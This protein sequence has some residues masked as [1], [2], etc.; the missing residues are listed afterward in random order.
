MKHCH[1]LKTA[2]PLF[3]IPEHCLPSPARCQ[4]WQSG[5]L[6]DI[7]AFGKEGCAEC[8]LYQ[9]AVQ[10]RGLVDIEI[11]TTLPSSGLIVTLSNFLGT[12][13]HPYKDQFIAAIVADYLPHPGAHLQILQN[14]QHARRL[15][16]SI[17]MPLWPQPGLIPRDKSRGAKFERIAFF[18]DLKNLA[19]ELAASEWRAKLQ[20]ELGLELI[21]REKER[22]HDY[23]DIDAVIGIRDFTGAGHLHKPP[24]KLHN[25]WL[26]GVPFIGGSDSAYAAERQSEDDFLVARTPNE[27]WDIL[28][29]LKANQDLRFRIAEQGLRRA[30]AF[31]PDAIRQQW[32]TLLVDELPARVHHWQNRSALSKTFFWTKQR[33]LFLLDRKLRW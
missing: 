12:S 32:K 29:R 7:I 31:T 6:H 33:S 13:F 5:Q 21:L 16:S 8:W 15:R 14:R 3:Y 27:L 10:L 24:T 25:A 17:F 4:G 28:K 26:A 2:K 20:H 30:T 11:V 23:S 19:P 1:L 22:W 9:T 18:G